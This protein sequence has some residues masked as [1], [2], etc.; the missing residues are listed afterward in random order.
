[1]RLNTKMIICY[2]TICIFTKSATKVYFEFL[3]FWNM[4]S[5]V[6]FLLFPNA[7][8]CFGCYCLIFEASSILFLQ[9]STNRF[10]L[11]NLI[12]T[13]SQFSIAVLR[14]LVASFNILL[15]TFNCSSFSFSKYCSFCSKAFFDFAVSLIASSFSFSYSLT[16]SKFCA[17]NS[18]AFFL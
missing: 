8:G 7:D 1:M 10:S 6:F 13:R 3:I 14:L 17:S 16:F 4:F 2:F 18:C 11:V 12:P 5:I 9:E 15:A